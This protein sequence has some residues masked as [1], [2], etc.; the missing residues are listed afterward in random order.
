MNCDEKALLALLAADVESHYKH[1]VVQYQ[2]ELYAF[3]LSKTRNKEDAQDI[4]Q[5]GFWRAYQALS[6]YS[7]Q[8]ILALKLRPWLYK[9][10]LNVCRNYLS[11]H[12][13]A[14]SVSLDLGDDAPALAIAEDR[15]VQPD[16]FVERAETRQELETL[17]EM[18]PAAYGTVV[19]L[20]YLDD[21]G[22][23]EIADI[24]QQDVGTIRVK[25]HRGVRFLRQTLASSC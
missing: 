3:I 18:L 10:T 8:R 7:P 13:P 22:Y 25:V 11:R 23:D 19:R 4:V 9:V 20:H 2:D 14:P 12:K 5:E 15:Q 24:L 6:G 21:F 1:L 17:V 16:V